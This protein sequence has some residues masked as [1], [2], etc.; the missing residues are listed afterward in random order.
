[1]KKTL[2][3]AAGFILLLAA[4]KKDDAAPAEEWYLSKYATVEVG[5]T[6]TITTTVKL[7]N[8]IISEITEGG[9]DAG[10]PWYFT[11]QT[12]FEGNRL[13]Q[14]KERSDVEPTP[15]VISSFEYTGDKISKI[16][17]YGSNQG[18]DW[19]ITGYHQMI[20]NA[21]GKVTEIRALG[22]PDE[23]YAVL[24]KITWEGENVKS[25][26]VF[27]VAGTDTSQ[28]NTELYLY[29]DKP[30]VHRA[31]FGNGFI[32]NGSPTAVEN[33]SANNLLKKEVYYQEELYTRVTYE[34]TYNERNQVKE[35]KVKT[36]N[37]KEPVSTQHK[38]TTYTYEKK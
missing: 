26:T 20:Y 14:L 37:V 21:Q 27:N 35:M 33:L 3:S 5:K 19:G 18:Q 36:E 11:T 30:G 16:N 10:T 34:R 29:D 2:L 4:C 1:M 28:A 17:Y 6:D 32:W 24:Y 38:I 8:N 31:L 7:T 23:G 12:V 9:I 22:V 15:K 25:L 13:T